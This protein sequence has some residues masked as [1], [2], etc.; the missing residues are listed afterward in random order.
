MV[1]QPSIVKKK[2]SVSPIAT[3]Q[4]P[5]TLSLGTTNW[6]AKK[7][8]R[9]LDK[10]DAKTQDQ[11]KPTRVINRSYRGTDGSELQL[12][13]T[14]GNAR[15]TFHDP[16]NCSLGSAAVMKDVGEET[17]HTKRGDIRVLEVTTYQDKPENT[18]LMMFFYV[19]EG[20]T[21]Q[22]TEQM[23]K[24]LVWQTFFGD[25]GQPSYF[26]RVMQESAGT[27]DAKKKQLI[28]FITALW[29]ASGPVFAGQVQG[30]FEPPPVSVGEE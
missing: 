10:L 11:L 26:I 7:D 23:H 13:I 14:A 8:D 9:F 29:E 6:V 20:K 19:A 1:A 2:E 27:D 15:W 5:L 28:D 4:V 30:A 25:A 17:I 3:S 18:V 16:H 22:R 12:F 21:L 24:K